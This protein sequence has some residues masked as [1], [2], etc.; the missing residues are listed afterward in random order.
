MLT[1][2]C[3]RRVFASGL[4]LILLPGSIL[5]FFHSLADGKE[6]KEA[7]AVPRRRTTVAPRSVALDGYVLM[8]CRLF[9]FRPVL[10]RS[11]C[12]TL[13]LSDLSH[14]LWDV[15]CAR[16]LSPVFLPLM[17]LPHL[18]AGRRSARRPLLIVRPTYFPTLGASCPLL[19][20]CLS[21]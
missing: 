1:Y 9:T 17:P 11:V 13:F 5:S 20:R 7:K 4:V 2:L 19:S 21:F 10:L 3:P 18:T 8:L 6:G 15:L 12:L 14:C 16:L